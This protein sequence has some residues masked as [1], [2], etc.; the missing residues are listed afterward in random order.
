MLLVHTLE[1]TEYD[2]LVKN[3]AVLFDIADDPSSVQVCCCST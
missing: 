2:E 3:I 1:V